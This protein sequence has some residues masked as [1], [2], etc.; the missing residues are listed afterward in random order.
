M[1]VR[2][3]LVAR[4]NVQRVLSLMAAGTGP[5]GHSA[6]SGRRCTTEAVLTAPAPTEM[7][8][9]RS[10]PP[11][12]PQRFMVHPDARA[13]VCVTVCLCVA[14]VDDGDCPDAPPGEPS[15]D[16]R[17]MKRIRCENAEDCARRCPICWLTERDNE[18]ASRIVLKTNRAHQGGARA[19]EIVVITSALAVFAAC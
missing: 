12:P 15:F 2:A 17:R 16:N 7:R 1:T 11:C 14:G 9:V 6:L 18:L 5:A 4:R 13:R 10:P 19:L 8:T 3:V